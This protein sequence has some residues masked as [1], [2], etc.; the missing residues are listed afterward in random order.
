MSDEELAKA[1]RELKDEIHSG[2]RISIGM[3]VGFWVCSS[4][5]L[6]VILSKIAGL[7]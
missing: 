5:T 6:F 2:I 4:I 7:W 1:I 3:Y